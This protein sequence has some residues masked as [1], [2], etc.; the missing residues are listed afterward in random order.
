MG[1]E[2]PTKAQ[3]N[4]IASNS[5]WLNGQ[6]FWIF[7]GNGCCDCNRGSWLCGDDF[8]WETG[9][10]GTDYDCGDDII[11]LDVRFYRDSEYM[12]YGSDMG[13]YTV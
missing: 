1:A 10:I 13:W 3:R 9:E 12:G 2:E 11:F 5:W 8:D 4:F 6:S 7:E